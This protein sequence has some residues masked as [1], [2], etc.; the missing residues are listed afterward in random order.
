M[1]IIEIVDPFAE[2]Q[3]AIMRERTSG[4][5]TRVREEGHAGRGQ[6]R[7][8]DVI[9]NVTGGRESAAQVARFY[10]VLEPRSAA[11]PA[12]CERAHRPPEQSV[13]RP[14]HH[15]LQTCPC[16]LSAAF[17]QQRRGGSYFYG[18]AGREA[19]N[20]LTQTAEASLHLYISHTPSS[21]MTEAVLIWC[22][23][24]SEKPASTSP[25]SSAPDCSASTQLSR[26]SA[27]ASRSRTLV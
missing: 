25:R 1:A 7:R 16:P 9:E 13:R 19:P 14:P 12:P 10:G 15:D 4:G 21:R 5:L 20:R 2:F 27:S 6:C 26:P 22:S 23:W 18:A 3:R 24:L 11:A 8:A 17:D